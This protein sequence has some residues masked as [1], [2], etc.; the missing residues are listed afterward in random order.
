MI[1][2][3]KNKDD[4]PETM[5]YVMFND[6]FF[7]QK[8]SQQLDNRAKMYIEGIDHAELISKYKISSRFDGTILNTDK[9]ST[10]CKTVLNVLYNPDVVFCIKECGENALELLYG[11]E[12]GNV[13]SDYALIPFEMSAVT[14]QTSKAEKI[15]TDYEEL[16]AW[17]EDEK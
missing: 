15:I 7:N 13:Y 5:E 12:Q 10:G 6:L 14:V 1:T 17:W 8:T 2:I 4:I 9:L 3:Y 16:K 11:L